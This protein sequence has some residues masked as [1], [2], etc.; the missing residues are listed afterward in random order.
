MCSMRRFSIERQERNMFTYFK[1]I[2]SGT[3]KHAYSKADR[4]RKCPRYIG[5]FTT[6]VQTAMHHLMGGTV[7]YPYCI[8]MFCYIRVYFKRCSTSTNE[9][10]PGGMVITQ[11]GCFKLEAALCHLVSLSCPFCVSIKE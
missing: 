6:S 1:A 10:L 3:V 8:H 9:Q 5:M 4:T 7:L 11:S 2:S